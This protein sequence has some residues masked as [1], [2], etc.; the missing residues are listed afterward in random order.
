MFFLTLPFLSISKT[1]IPKFIS[2]N[3]SGLITYSS[4]SSSSITFPDNFINLTITSDIFHPNNLETT[5]D[6]EPI[7]INLSSKSLSGNLTYRS[8]IF[9]FNFAELAKPFVS[10]NINLSNFGFAHCIFASMKC[11]RC[12]YVSP[13]SE[14]VSLMFRKISEQSGT[15]FTFIRRHWKKLSIIVCCVG[16]RFLFKRLSK[17]I[18]QTS[19]HTKVKTE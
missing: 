14:I 8:Q 13:T 18:G 17:R 9:P 7:L 4:S 1:T 16:L 5:F 6:N 19:A 2:G 3:W 11:I 15:Q 12:T 10:S